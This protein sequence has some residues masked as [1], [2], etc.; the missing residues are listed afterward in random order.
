MIKHALSENLEELATVLAQHRKGPVVTV[1]DIEAAREEVKVVLGAML[2]INAPM[3]PLTILTRLN[4]DWAI[5]SPTNAP[6][7][8]LRINS[9]ET[10]G[11]V[12]SRQG[13][14]GPIDLVEQRLTINALLYRS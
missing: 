3:I 13:L 12:L 10:L 6:L 4:E 8:A 7:S 11:T 14:T 5:L 2:K 1:N 9:I